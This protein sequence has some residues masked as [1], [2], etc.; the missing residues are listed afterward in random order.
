[1]DVKEYTESGPGIL[2]PCPVVFND[3]LTSKSEDTEGKCAVI[4]PDKSAYDHSVEYG[5]NVEIAY[6]DGVAELLA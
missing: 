1:M 2:M 3:L 5:T 4:S 6:S